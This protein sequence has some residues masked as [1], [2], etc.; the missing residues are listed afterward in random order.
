MPPPAMRLGS[1]SQFT[2]LPAG[3]LSKVSEPLSVSIS[4]AVNGSLSIAT[5]LSSIEMCGGYPATVPATA[6]A[7]SSPLLCAT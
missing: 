6:A 2:P 1:T 4:A 7:A 5:G 3:P